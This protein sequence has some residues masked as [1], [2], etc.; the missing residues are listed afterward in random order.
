M[1]V[2]QQVQSCKSD[3]LKWVEEL[4]I[5]P[6]AC[7]VQT[8]GL[9]QDVDSIRRDM[10]E[11][12]KKNKAQ[13]RTLTRTHIDWAR[14]GAAVPLDQIAAHF[15]VVSRTQPKEIAMKEFATYKTLRASMRPGIGNPGK[16]GGIGGMSASQT[17]IGHGHNPSNASIASDSDLASEDVEN[18]FSKLMLQFYKRANATVRE[19]ET[20]L[21]KTHQ[22]T[23]KL[24]H[25]YGCDESTKW[26]D[27][28]L[29][30]NQFRDRFQK[31]SREL[32]ILAQ[33]Q[34]R[35]EMISQQKE[36][37]ANKLK[38]RKNRQ[39]VVNDTKNN[40]DLD[41][42]DNKSNDKNAQSA[43]AQNKTKAMYAKYMQKKKEA[44]L[45]KTQPDQQ[46]MWV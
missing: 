38:N 42:V 20:L 32:G 19:V 23:K 40:V 43:A 25:F 6:Q 27:I 45:T 9:E 46:Q 10:D 31:A 30:F 11:I 7:K 5:L 28:F 1:Y 34:K 14:D 18:M 41:N 3:A 12:E 29:I 44:D 21:K 15:R 2:V 8:N 37:L 17:N 4:E 35:K 16:I 33:K 22:N 39:E 26:E 24:C 13:R 36:N